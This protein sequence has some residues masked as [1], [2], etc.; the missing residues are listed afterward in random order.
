MPTPG[1]TGR[2]KVD[3]GK[4]AKH[5]W[6]AKERESCPYCEVERPSSCTVDSI[7]GKSRAV[8]SMEFYAKL[9]KQ[10]VRFSAG[11]QV[12]SNKTIESND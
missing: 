6:E 12:I 4:C 7:V 1:V 5:G 10:G 8:K 3:M 11:G 2:R 9:R